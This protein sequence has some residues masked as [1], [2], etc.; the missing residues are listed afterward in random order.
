[1]DISDRMIFLTSRN[2]GRSL[3]VDN[4]QD[5]LCQV[6]TGPDHSL[7]FLL[8]DSGFDVW[9]GNYRGEKVVFVV[10]LVNYQ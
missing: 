2:T 3:D 7:A 1:M 8:A 10:V 6:V 9:L 5:E 4:V